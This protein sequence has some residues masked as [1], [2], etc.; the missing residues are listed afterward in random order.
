MES[1]TTFIYTIHI[2]EL[3]AISFVSLFVVV[4][5]NPFHI[6][7]DDSIWFHNLL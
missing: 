1:K 6:K 3:N 7:S 5:I 4:I 2:I